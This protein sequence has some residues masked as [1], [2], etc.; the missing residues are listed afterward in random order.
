[1]RVIGMFR[2]F[3]AEPFQDANDEVVRDLPRIQ[4]VD[5]VDRLS[6]VK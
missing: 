3:K 2:G 1:M 6:R 5:R 4:Q